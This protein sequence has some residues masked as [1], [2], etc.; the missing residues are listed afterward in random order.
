MYKN[1]MRL[2]TKF[3]F[4]ATCIAVM[5]TLCIGIFWLFRDTA[6]NN[7]D[8]Q[9]SIDSEHKKVLEDQEAQLTIYSSTKLAE[10]VTILEEEKTEK[11]AL[12][13][14]AIEAAKL[15]EASLKRTSSLEDA[16]RNFLGNEV[17]KVGLVYYDLSS[18]DTVLINANKTYTAASTF[19]VP[20]AMIIYDQIS[21]GVRKE[22]DT[23]KFSEINR[24]GG[25]GILLNN[26][27]TSPIMIST[28]VE[29][30]LRYSD[31]IAANMLITSLDFDQF[32]IQ[33]DIR[34][35]IITNHAN[36]EITALGAFNT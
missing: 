24:G 31:N 20:L 5:I 35:G 7:A 36:N 10:G 4:A 9:P 32:K 33:E 28:L 23:I 30:A 13:T 11:I 6:A 15:A 29:Y 3:V 12:N 21:D 22:T 19:K 17:D 25:T 2:R 8:T 27:L 26:N 16:L 18:G 14:A 1:R 34:L